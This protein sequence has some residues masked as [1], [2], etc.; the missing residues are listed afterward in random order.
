MTARETTLLSEAGEFA[1]DFMAFAGRRGLSAGALT[2]AAGATEAG[3]LA[4]VAPVLAVA[5]GAPG[6]WPARVAERL[7]H[8]LDIETSLGRLALLMAALAGLWAV[9]AIAVWHRD[10]ALSTLQ[11]DFSETQR[12]RVARALAAAPWARVNA[13]RHARVSQALGQDVQRIGQAAYVMIQASV[14]AVMLVAQA[15]IILSLAPLLAV[16]A[17]VLMAVGGLALSA[18]L[19]RA[20]GL[21][22]AVTRANLDLNEAAGRFLG[23]LKLAS[24]QN[25]Q[26]PFV[27]RFEEQ[28][29]EVRHRQIVFLRQQSA[30]R[31]AV[32]GVA[33]G[34]AAVVSLVS[35]GWLG[36]PLPLLAATILILTRMGGPAT[37]VQQ[38]LQQ[39]AY[40]LPAYAQVN[41]LAAELGPQAAA[42][43]PIPPPTT[44]WAGPITFR[45]VTY[46]HPP[47]D[48]KEE[49][50]GEGGVEDI[51]FTLAAGEM[52]GLTG[53]SGAGK[54]TLADLLVGLIQP[55]SGEVL[56]GQV[57]LSGS[58]SAAWRDHVS[59]VAQDPYLFHAS[60]RENL[61]WGACSAD[62][63]ALWNALEAAAAADLV[64]GLPQ[65][66]DTIVGERGM[67]LSGGERQRL[68][69]ARAL[70]RGGN[71][72]VL[73]EATSA[74][75]VATEHA[76]LQRL[77]TRSGSTLIIAHRAESL[78]LC[79]RVMVLEK[80]RLRTERGVQGRTR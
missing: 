63:P 23:G 22:S 36:A 13:L 68:A 80:G 12:A 66:I 41:T 25:Q 56:I 52:L 60:V 76:I 1:R 47:R 72:L 37:Q 18:L 24:S 5:A 71:L 53:P 65:G 27:E 33:F 74:I 79:D 77:R 15:A 35:F 30:A 19:S 78:A 67:L 10:A 43:F 32:S 28:L 42:S 48:G 69:L 40:T 20:H 7:F 58:L 8:G 38:A 3:G 29:A 2:V 34:A 49:G 51:S 14:A 4:L 61:T 17:L 59:Y 44:D 73:D 55:Q 26:G 31:L 9:R 75:D 46:L 16:L 62:E 45:K 11:V 70:L 64:A 57:P 6:G 21:G 54:S 50:G 39:L